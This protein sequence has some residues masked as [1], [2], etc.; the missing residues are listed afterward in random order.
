[1]VPCYVDQLYPRV[2]VATLRLLEHYGCEVVYPRTQ[3]C[4]G[5]PMANTGM[6]DAAL[7]TYRNTVV[8]FADAEYVVCPS[9][10]CAYHV[11]HHYGVLGDGPDVTRVRERTY[12]LCEF[13]HDVLRVT[14][15]PGRLPARVGLHQSCHGLRGLRLGP[16]SERQVN[17]P[18]K[19][20][21]LLARVA[22]IELVAP[23]R[24]DE[25]CGFGGTFAVAQPELSARMGED[26]LRDHDAAGA[27]VI[28]STDVSCLMHLEGL[29]R[30]AGSRT[31]V[32]HVAEVLAHDW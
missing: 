18:E 24:P 26:K 1:M 2:A 7:P 5:Q 30:R 8:A 22:D 6:E 29:L 20:G 10:S 11:R 32:M 21:S 16:G 23:A 4:C 14:E 3:A 28:T 25:C 9:G 15:V 12:E 17:A 31:R 13:L 27:E 19:V